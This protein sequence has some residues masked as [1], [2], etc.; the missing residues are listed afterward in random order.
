MPSK[1]GASKT[2]KNKKSSSKKNIDKKS[3]HNEKEEEIEDF[4]DS[5]EF[6]NSEDNYKSEESEES[7][8][9]KEP[10]SGGDSE[11]P[12]TQENE[13][14][15]DD[16]THELD[17][18]DEKDPNEDDKYDPIDGVEEVEDSDEEIEKED[19]DE[20]AAEDEVVEG[21]VE[22]EADI[23]AE[24]K[25]CYLKKL[26]KDFIVLDED[27]SNIY[28][29][30]EHKKVADEDRI[31]DDVMTYYE[32]VRIIG[33]R[34]QQFNFGSQPLVKGL[35]GLHPAKMAYLELLAK[36]TPF[37]IRRLFAWKKIRGLAHR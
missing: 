28:G 1:R 6:A 18:D 30:I 29:K 37:I 22:D 14:G 33:T 20:Q 24:A 25:T 21:E 5:A 8:E 16:A 17:V 4:Y 32:M 35:E 23:P 31:T 12:E 34:A 15:D 3:N 7:E 19:D 27:D 9:S 2:E 26:N 11:E 10:I 36:M 13:L